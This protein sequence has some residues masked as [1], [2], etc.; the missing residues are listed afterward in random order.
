MP[1]THPRP[2]GVAG[3]NPQRL[4]TRQR[5]ELAEWIRGWRLERVDVPAFVE[6]VAKAV[7]LYPALKELGDK[8]SAGAIR[9][10]LDAAISDGRRFLKTL[11]A[12]DGNS[13]QYLRA[14]THG[15]DVQKEAG[16]VLRALMEV[17]Q[18]VEI[19]L[20]RGPRRRPERVQFASLLLHAL[21]RHSSAEASSVPA[22]IFEALLCHA[23]ELAGEKPKDLHNLAARTLAAKLK[24]EDDGAVLS[25]PSPEQ[26]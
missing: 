17:R 1:N 25:I 24:I 10:N 2:S 26:V 16:E 21:R 15:R 18:R 11:N 7:W 6:D 8:T 19:F 20:K 3:P 4:T 5:E 12:L 14:H 23:F 22:G 13:L 9:R